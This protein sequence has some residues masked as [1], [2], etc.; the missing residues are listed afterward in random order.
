[1][2]TVCWS[3][4]FG[5]AGDLHVAVETGGRDDPVLAERRQVD[6]HRTH[7]RAARRPSAAGR[8]AEGAVA[9]AAG[10]D[11]GVGDLAVRDADG[12]EVRRAAALRAVAEGVGA[13]AGCARA[14]C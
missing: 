9:A 5:E 13:V 8:S 6:R 10:A 4:A 3:W 14:R 7:A 2:V 12:D 11:P 1:L